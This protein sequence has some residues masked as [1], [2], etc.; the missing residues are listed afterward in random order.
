[1][2]GRPDDLDPMDDA[3]LVK[4]ALTALREMKQRVQTLERSGKEP[5]AIIGMGCRF[6]GKVFGPA[7]FW[8]LLANAEDAVGVVP[9]DRWMTEQFY[10]ADRYAPGKISSRSGAFLDDISRFD[11]ELFG[12]SPREASCMDPQQRLLL[13]VCWASLEDA[14]IPADSLYNS[15]TGVFVGICPGGYGRKLL[16]TPA[17]P[18]V[19]DGYFNTGTA[20]SV[21]AGRLSFTLGLVGPC[22][23]VDTACSSSLVS[24]HY[25]CQSL[26]LGE[27]DLAIAGGV[28]AIVTPEESVSFSKAQVLSLDGRCKTFDA[29]ADGYVRGEGCGLVVLERLSDSLARGR[30]IFA[31]IRG[32]AVNQDGPSGGLTVPNGPSQEALIRRALAHA[33]V[34]ASSVDYVETHGTGTAL[35]D[36][37]EVGALCNV[38]LESARPGRK[39]ILGS[40]KTNFGHLE[41]AAGIA[42]LCKATLALKNG[43]IPANLH[44]RTPNPHIRW[45]DFPLLVPKEMVPWPTADVPRFAA[46]SSFGFSGTNAH[47]I[48]EEPPAAADRYDADLL[49][50]PCVFAISAKTTAALEELCRR[51]IAHL[52]G[53]DEPDV[54]RLCAT[55]TAG[56]AHL[57][58]RLAVVTDAVA[59]LLTKLER[60]DRGERP[61]DLAVTTGNREVPPRIAFMF[62]GQG[63]QYGG[64]GRLLYET[65]PVFRDVLDR[66]DRI[67]GP[68][69]GESLL[70]VMFASG[71]AADGRVDDIRFTHPA[72]FSLE[73]ALAM[74]WRHYGVESAVLVGHSTG[75]YAAA[76]LAGVFSLEDGLSLV[77]HRGRLMRALPQTGKMIAVFAPAAEVEASLRPYVA[78]A[79]LA[80][81]NGPGN[82]VVSGDVTAIVELQ[83]R[84]AA[85][86]IE[87]KDVKVSQAAHSPLI[88]P[89][90]S[91][92]RRIATLVNY[93]PPTIDIIST[94]FGRQVH[95][96]LCTPDYWCEH[97]RNT[98]RFTDAISALRPFG[99][100]ALVEIGP[101]ATLVR[102]AAEPDMG[103]SAAFIPSLNAA[104]PDTTAIREAVAR[105]YCLGV[106][107]AWDNVQPRRSGSLSSLPTYPFQGWRYWPDV[108]SEP[109]TLAPSLSAAPDRSV[110]PLVGRRI[111]SAVLPAT[112]RQF[113]LTLPSPDLQYL[114]DHRVFGEPVFPAAAYVAIAAE[115]ARHLDLDAACL[116]IADLVLQSPLRLGGS[117][118]HR[119]NVIV[120]PSL[121][122]SYIFELYGV[123]DRIEAYEEWTLHALARLYK[124]A[125][126]TTVNDAVDLALMQERLTQEV[127]VKAYYRTCAALGL[128]YGP[129]FRTIERA[130]R[131][132][133][134]GLGWVRL[135]GTL[136]SA[137]AAQV[138][139]TILDGCLQ[140]LGAAIPEV[141]ARSAFLPAGIDEVALTG[142]LGDGV[143]CHAVLHGPPSP[144]ADSYKADFVLFDE[145]GRSKGRLSGVQLIRAGAETFGTDGK[146]WERWLHR[147]AWVREVDQ[148]TKRIEKA[149]VL[150]DQSR[151]W[152]FL[153][154][155]GGVGKRLQ[156]LL[157]QRGCRCATVSGTMSFTQSAP[158]AFS[159]DICAAADIEQVFETLAT[160]GV[161]R[162]SIVDLRPSDAIAH[163][164][165]EPQALAAGEQHCIDLLHLLQ[166]I[167]RTARIAV[168]RFHVVTREAQ[169][170]EP[171]LFRGIGASPLLGMMRVA[172]L[173]Y[174]DTHFVAI[175]LE[176]SASPT[177]AHILLQ[178][179]EETRSAEDEVVYRK[180]ERHIPRLIPHK[181]KADGTSRPRLTVPAAPFRLALRER[182]SI[183]GL[184]LDRCDRRSPG[185]GEIEI[186][187]RSAGLNFMD[188]MDALGTLPLQR[189]W[190]GG[191][192]AGEIVAIGEGVTGFDIGTPVIAIALGALAQFVVTDARL[193]VRMPPALSFHEAATI[194]GSFVTAYYALVECARLMPG[195]SVLIHAAAG[196]TGSAAVQLARALGARIFGTA[197]RSKWLYLRSS[198]VDQILDSR[199]L[200]FGEEVRT[201]TGGRG[202]DVVLNAMTGPGMIDASLRAIKPGGRFVEMSKRGALDADDPRLAHARVTYY[203]IDLVDL[204]VS[205]PSLVSSML[206]KII[207][208]FDEGA[209][210][211]L[212]LKALDI[213]E[214]IEGFRCMQEAA[215]IGKIVF[216]MSGSGDKSAERFFL[217][218]TATYLIAGGTGG[219][220]L[221]LAEWMAERGAR[222]LVLVG[223]RDP[224]AGSQQHRL[225]AVQRAGAKVVLKQCD[226]ADGD[227]LKMLLDEMRADMPPLKGLFQLA[228]VIDDGAMVGTTPE[229]LSAV[230][231]PKV[232]G[233]WNLHQLTASEP[234][235]FFV[236]FSSVSALLGNFGQAGYAAANVFLD[237]MAEYRRSLGLP[238]LSINWPA[239]SDIGAAAGRDLDKQLREKAMEPL[240]P[241]TGLQILRELMR[242]ADSHIAVLPVDW[243][244]YQARGQQRLLTGLLIE[245]RRS[246][247]ETADGR[248]AK[249]LLSHLRSLPEAERSVFSKMLVRE[250]IL[251]ALRLPPAYPLDDQQALSTIGF[252]SLMGMELR[253]RLGLELGFSLSVSKVLGKSTI[254]QISR[255]VLS[256]ISKAS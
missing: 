190:L 6:P 48:L 120:Q 88:E 217:D 17:G 100:A 232:A 226:I 166:A 83:G 130:W 210:R 113:E 182:G 144:D 136:Q 99:C 18:N 254:E 134:E 220:G 59:D 228:A 109:P 1:M 128:D 247:E 197:S 194:P 236:M 41:A 237:A 137:S 222:N 189:N 3:T 19:I 173:E 154:D 203:R 234:L 141:F 87:T 223:R 49:R 85:Q 158:D 69:L 163:I 46:V 225:D 58:R 243:G 47:V 169:P 172:A 26:R 108:G 126:E 174:P 241:D 112:L 39:L 185:A 253:H 201:M 111:V 153:E 176:G 95:E 64:M 42:G 8:R 192:C 204:C 110:S 65:E 82:V 180:G 77:T 175:D 90:I 20:P 10:D 16:A 206:E 227:A 191:E 2:T 249:L 246:R 252:D 70:R 81:I 115:A 193:L 117:G 211:P 32:S 43:Q 23:A 68:L 118:R 146:R 104:L 161:R 138:H 150:A 207:A 13:E 40:V 24:L 255:E 187:V 250:R 135:R 51:H 4:R 53:A 179:L 142:P 233:T 35:G 78:R 208:L 74:L 244:S 72:M 29:D 67:A 27:C 127:D 101:S 107:I 202:V 15:N 75:E 28:N 239:W 121:P 124:R 181:S 31:V 106:S 97:L 92:F 116:V 160:A 45:R 61:S 198:R 177:D 56:R 199:T 76:C 221:L 196:G 156:E 188:V 140:I 162:V 52:R 251:S 84:F 200:D 80:A 242:G 212:P 151:A 165:A 159:V 22:L 63:S 214:A 213:S 133:A 71:D 34:D 256:H 86:G 91:E 50:G 245:G 149:E 238:A 248:D 66:C 96:E 129:S 132:A 30:R 155:R 7:D 215:N 147:V 102:L 73:Y 5:V 62:S 229:R 14:N 145:A 184:Y 54:Y 36:P 9:A 219:L 57:P 38:Y 157:R 148:G 218:Q 33:S 79:G 103:M 98:V 12:I 122:D 168:D 94:V 240:R 167:S 152:L 195:E 25:A 139:P 178:E 114:S 105:L 89:M 119:L 93:L 171:K 143:W 11:N 235:D 231:R 224:K 125:R 123:P 131:G 230:L 164:G 21:A 60:F 44:F 37:I 209:L 186:R 183:D 170:F 55:T 216:G 205:D